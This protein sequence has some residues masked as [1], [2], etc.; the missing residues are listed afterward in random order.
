MKVL[1]MA[2]TVATLAGIELASGCKSHHV[3]V[4][5]E[6]RTGVAL[7]L[8]EIDYPSA[9]F[10]ANTMAQDAILHY[11]VQLRGSGT[12]TAQYSL[13]GGKTVHVSGPTLSENQDGALKIVLEP[14]GKAEFTPLIEPG[15]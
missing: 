4:T 8:V 14:D 9:S 3:D 11:R 12:V 10:G 6:N 5:V 15:K 13:G 2:A 7:Q 1:R